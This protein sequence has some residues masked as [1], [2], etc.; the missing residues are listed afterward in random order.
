M[1]STEHLETALKRALDGDDQARNTLISI[2][3]D[4]FHATASRLLGLNPRLKRWEATDDVLQNTMIRLNQS[5]LEVRPS[6]VRELLGLTRLQFSRALTDLARKH[7]GTKGVGKNHAT[8]LNVA[9]AQPLE[10][11]GSGSDTYNPRKLH[12]WIEFHEAIEHL[13][14]PLREVFQLCWYKMMTHEEMAKVLGC[15]TKTI[16]RRFRDACVQLQQ[17]VNSMPGSN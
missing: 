12:E 14:E 13:D 4:R 17:K 6:N 1:S 2:L 9:G 5:L 11:L 16:Q 8:G 15:S 7:Y 3:M 10:Q